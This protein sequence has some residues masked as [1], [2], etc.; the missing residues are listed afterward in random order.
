MDERKIGELISEA[1]ENYNDKDY[2]HFMQWASGFKGK[3]EERIVSQIADFI[4]KRNM[5]PATLI[6]RITNFY[7]KEILK[8]LSNKVPRED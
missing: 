6:W 2:T 3:E 5:S 7:E 8:Y 4:Y 1:K